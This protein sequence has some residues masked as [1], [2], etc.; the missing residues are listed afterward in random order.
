M[1]PLA[2]RACV[3]VCV[4][5]EQAHVHAHTY[6]ALVVHNA[7]SAFSVLPELAP[8]R[9]KSLW[10]MGPRPPPAF[11]QGWSFQRPACCRWLRPVGGN[12]R[13][14]SVTGLPPCGHLRRQTQLPRNLSDVSL[15]PQEGGQEV[16]AQSA[17]TRSKWADDDCKPSRVPVWRLGVE[18]DHLVTLLLCSDLG[19]SKRRILRL[20]RPV[21]Q[22]S[23]GLYLDCTH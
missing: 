2:V 6:K 21:G 5:V 23:P 22:D 18:S 19:P 8:Q 12:D 4:Y 15:R 13:D 20:R 17:K 3:C 9:R 11:S 10:F 14:C 16:K 7:R 1:V